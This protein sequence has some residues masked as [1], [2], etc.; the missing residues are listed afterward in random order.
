[1]SNIV[2]KQCKECFHVL[3][4]STRM[5]IVR[6]LQNESR[7]VSEITEGLGVTQPTVSYHLKMLDGLGLIKKE[8]RGRSVYYTFNK[9]YP[10]HNCGVFAVPVKLSAS[11]RSE[12]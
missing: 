2:Q 3:A 8:K 5:K 9:N 10:C 12:K 7:N 11:W 6:G 1:M 4:D